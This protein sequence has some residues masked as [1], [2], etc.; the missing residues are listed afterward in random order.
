MNLLRDYM[1]IIPQ[2]MHPNA[3]TQEQWGKINAQVCVCAS[4][5]EER[6]VTKTELPKQCSI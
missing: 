1:V 6:K 2:I 3:V 5:M 4:R